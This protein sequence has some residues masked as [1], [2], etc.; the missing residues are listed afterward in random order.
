MKQAHEDLDLALKF[1]LYPEAENGFREFM[2]NIELSLCQDFLQEEIDLNDFVLGDSKEE[3]DYRRWCLDEILFINPLNDLGAYS[4][5]SKDSLHLPNIVVP[6]GE[7][8]YYAG[9]FNQLKQEFISARFLLYEG[10]HSDEVHYSDRDV[11]LMNTF[12]YPLYSLAVEKIKIAFR[13]AYSLFDKIAFF[14]NYY[15]DLGISERRISF[16]TI[17]YEKCNRDKGINPKFE[18]LNNNPLRGLFWLSK[19]L[20]E[21]RE[22]FVEAL[23]P[24]AQEIE[25]LRQHAEHRYLKVHDSLFSLTQENNSERLGLADTL[26]KS[27]SRADFGDKALRMLRLS[28][29]SLIYLCLVIQA[30]EKRRMKE[31]S[32]DSPIMPMVLDSLEDSWKR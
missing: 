27:I 2:S 26:A 11:T 8:P 4:I 25:S 15:I 5:A 32:P 6:V 22:G 21:K 16:K 7:G 1:K 29:A 14:L 9:T 3:S 17:W 23:E 12:D 10:L 30:E 31:R 13:V 28:R 20:S 19:D 24:D 18:A